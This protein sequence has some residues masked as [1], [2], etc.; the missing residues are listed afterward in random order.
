[1]N[2]LTQLEDLVKEKKYSDVAQ[3]LAVRKLSLLTWAGNEIFEQAVKQLGASF[4]PYT[5]VPH[6]AQVWKRIQELQ[7]DLRTQLEKDF[8]TLCVTHEIEVQLLPDT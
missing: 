8:D 5:S 1:M 3:T 2:A 7:G 4:K 6:I